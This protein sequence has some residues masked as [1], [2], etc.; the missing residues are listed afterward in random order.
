MRKSTRRQFLS[1]TALTGAAGLTGLSSLSTLAQTVTNTPVPPALPTPNGRVF[2]SQNSSS[3]VQWNVNNTVVEQMADRL[4]GAY[5]GVSNAATA[6]KRLVTP[7]DVVGLKVFASPGAATS[8]NKAMVRVVINALKAAGLP[9]QNIIVWDK[10]RFD[11]ENAQFLPIFQR[12]VQVPIIG[13][14]PDVGYGD[15]PSYDFEVTGTLIWGDRDFNAKKASV[16][17]DGSGNT[18]L[19]TKS[20]FSRIVTQRCTKLIN[21]ASLTDH[22]DFGING[23]LVNM[24]IGSVDNNRRF[25]TSPYYGVPPIPDIYSNPVIKNKVILNMMDAIITGYA[26]GPLFKPDFSDQTGQIFISNDPVAI[27]TLCLRELIALRKVAG[28]QS[29]SYFGAHVPA[30]AQAGLGVGDPSKINLQTV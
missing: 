4:I 19:S 7:Q 24:A 17:A 3:I 5:Y 8:T 28:I 1:K 14:A 13:T 9:S 6:M 30:C 15:Q 29:P 26:G 2:M 27:D 11:L 23:C 20:Y 22:P 16:D 21:M 18:Q 12:E 10:F 25:G